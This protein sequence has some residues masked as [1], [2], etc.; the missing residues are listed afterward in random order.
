MEIHYFDTSV[1]L[2]LLLHDKNSERALSFW[3]NSPMRASSKLL[4]FE[5]ATVINRECARLPELLQKKWK[6]DAAAWLSRASS[7]MALYE[8]NDDVLSVV[9]EETR[10]NRARTLDAIHLATALVFKKA[11]PTTIVTFDTRMREVAEILGFSV[12]G[13]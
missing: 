10:F 9:S 6:K 1:I 13:I 4:L 8:V 11:I 3:N 5:C 7:S 2:S 12:L